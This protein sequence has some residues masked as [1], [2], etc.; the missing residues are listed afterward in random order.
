MQVIYMRCDPSVLKICTVVPQSFIFQNQFHVLQNEIRNQMNSDGSDHSKNNP[1][2]FK[3]QTTQSSYRDK[4]EA[5]DIFVVV[6]KVP[7]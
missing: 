1:Q 4:I 7:I 5:F 3:L 2:S 6:D